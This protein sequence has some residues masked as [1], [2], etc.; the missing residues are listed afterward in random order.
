MFIEIR[1]SAEHDYVYINVNQIT[2]ITPYGG[3]MCAVYT[4]DQQ[5]YVSYDNIS[6]VLNKLTTILQ[7]K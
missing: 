1:I 5:K 6:T 2:A 3:D 4:S 7:S